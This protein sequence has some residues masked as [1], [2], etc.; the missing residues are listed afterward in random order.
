MKDKGENVSVIQRIVT[1]PHADEKRK[2]AIA[3]SP[4]LSD[5][6]EPYVTDNGRTLVYFKKGADVAKKGLIFEELRGYQL[7]KRLAPGQK[8][9]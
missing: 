3:K 6:S 8:E 1:D 5:C 2:Q 9:F 7:D 4:K